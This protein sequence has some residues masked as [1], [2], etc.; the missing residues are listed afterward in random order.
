MSEKI[1]L[2]LWRLYPPHFREAYRDA[3][4]QLFR[5]RARHEKG[6][7][8]Q[9]RLWLDL[10]TDLASSLPREH[11][12]RQPALT[13]IPAGQGSDGAPSFYVLGGEPPRLGALLYGGVLSLAIFGSISVAIGHGA[14]RTALG[15]WPLRQPPTD[16]YYCA[17][18]IHEGVQ[19]AR[20]I[21]EGVKLDAAQRHRL[22]EEVGANLRQYY[23]DRTAAQKVADAL[24][25]R[26]KSG[27][28]AAAEG[29]DF[30]GLLTRQMQS[31]SHDMHLSTEYSQDRLPEHPP[32]ETPESLARYRKA[33]EQEHCMF[34][35]VEI[36][37]HGVGYLKL[38]F[39]PDTSVCGPTA[40]AAMASLNRADAIIFDL[41]DN[42]GGFENMVTL[43][44]GYLFDHPE[45]MYSPRGAPTE[46]SWT[47]SPVP[48]NRL[49]D[50]PVYVLTSASTWS[51]AEQFSYDLKMLGRATLVG[52]TT[53]G[54]AHAGVFHRIDDHFGVGI[55][56]VKPVNPFGEADWEGTGVEPD[57][58]VKAADALETAKKLAE[59]WLQNK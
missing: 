30:A 4:L 50:K 6:F 47:H 27:D 44:A 12:Y 45:Y 56:E 54:G 14:T 13:G 19:C 20:A 33:M 16:V 5:D 32:E 51:G 43:I 1:Y 46:K 52:E 34:R 18:A 55:P 2:W 36:L 38:N 25:A 22:I 28:D 29:Q 24:L 42:T 21:D 15:S 23:F 53:R 35:K 10:L 48:G 8:P 59:S 57:V 9:L 11:L 41:R 58:K 49:A 40:T 7:F 37:P 39:F 31:V 26:E 17:R 3:A